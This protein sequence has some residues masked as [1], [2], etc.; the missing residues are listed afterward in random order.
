[1]NLLNI[2]TKTWV[3]E[4]LAECDPSL[5]LAEKLGYV[6]GENEV[7]G[8]IHPYFVKKYG[9]NPDCLITTGSGDNP[10]TLSS[11][12]CSKAGDLIISFGTSDTCMFVVDKATPMAKAG[13][14]FCNPNH[15]DSF[16]GLLCFRNGSLAREKIRD[17][18]GNGNWESFNESASKASDQTHIGL[19]FLDPEIQPANAQGVCYFV[20]KND[21]SYDQVQEEAVFESDY[22]TS[23]SPCKAII[24]S[25]TLLKQYYCNKL[26]LHPTRIVVVGGGA[27]NKVMV[28]SV[29]NVFGVDVYSNTGSNS[30]SLGSCYRV[31]FAVDYYKTGS[32]QEMLEKIHPGLD[33]VAR[34]DAVAHAQ[35]KS[36]GFG[37]LMDDFYK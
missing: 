10:C 11:M 7:L 14:I 3:P 5:K 29:A 37:R 13:H 22:G 4:V 20:Q 27:Q 35:Y 15:P 12:P 1:M 8:K 26:G 34:P 18:Y 32:F 9:F 23:F 17:R 31:M 24:D 30:A 28:Q 36:L 25:Q 2:K 33:L 19:F 16:M 21:G 6:G